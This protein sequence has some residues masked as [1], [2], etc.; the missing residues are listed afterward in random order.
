[1]IITTKDGRVFEF[2]ENANEEYA[3]EL[4]DTLLEKEQKLADAEA[5]NALPTGDVWYD[6]SRL[7]T[8][9]LFVESDINVYQET[10][11]ADYEYKWPAYQAPELHDPLT[12]GERAIVAELREIRRAVLADRRIIP[13]VTGEMTRSQV[14]LP[15]NEGQ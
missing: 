1:M 9:V 10:T 14:V 15:T 13:D 3:N 8:A 7:K 2:G 4:I 12:P 6:T 11:R 5:S